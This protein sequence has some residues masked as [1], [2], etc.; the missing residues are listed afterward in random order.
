MLMGTLTLRDGPIC[1]ATQTVV[2]QAG[3][4]KRVHFSLEIVLQT[5]LTIFAS[6]AETL[7][8]I[9]SRAGCGSFYFIFRKMK[10]YAA[11]TMHTRMHD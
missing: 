2:I 11:F 9:L 1:T 3:L 8:G 10:I 4:E 6:N 7:V 5:I